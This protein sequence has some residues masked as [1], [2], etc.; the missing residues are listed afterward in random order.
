M[1]NIMRADLYKL[2][3]SKVIFGIMAG[4]F[5]VLILGNY[6]ALNG[7][8]KMTFM[9]DTLNL[10]EVTYS[11]QGSKIMPELLKGSNILLFFLIPIVLNIFISDFK[12]STVKNTVSYKYKRAEI[13]FSKV[14]L[15]SILS[16]FLIVVYA[17][18]GLIL[19]LIF[20]KMQILIDTQDFVVSIKIIL[21]QMPI[22][23]GVIGVILLIGILFQS[24]IA[25]ILITILY[26]FVVTIIAYALKLENISSYEPITC[27]DKAAYLVNLSNNEINQIIGIGLILT[28][29]S[30]LL[31]SYIY[32]HRDFK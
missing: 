11:L 32:S 5:I 3:K 16:F 13:Y 9:S 7:D 1:L 19:N 20:N 12:Y 30:L 25:V 22:Y 2:R 24:S 21:T 29:V 31:G 23:I 6:M 10:N 17:A 14:I 15:C 26:P 8:G 18:L 28:V 4:L 27:L